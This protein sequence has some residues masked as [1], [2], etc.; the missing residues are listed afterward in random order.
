MEMKV[1]LKAKMLLIKNKP[2]EHNMA[3][4]ITAATKKRTLHCKGRPLESAHRR[5]SPGQ[6]E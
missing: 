3:A 4:S 6:E 5:I 1:C 2:S